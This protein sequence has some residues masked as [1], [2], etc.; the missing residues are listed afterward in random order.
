MWN[1]FKGAL[2]AA[3][4]ILPGFGPIAPDRPGD[5]AHIVVAGA[6]I[7]SILFVLAWWGRW[8][9][10]YKARAIRTREADILSANK[11]ID[12]LEDAITNAHV[13]GDEGHVN[14]LRA[15][16]HKARADIE[17]WRRQ[18]REINSGLDPE[19]NSPDW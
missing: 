18:I 1:V 13:I 3:V 4:L 5:A 19:R 9:V 12:A 17:H 14:S 8:P 6:I 16:Q 7:I 10:D 15:E 2:L 11:F